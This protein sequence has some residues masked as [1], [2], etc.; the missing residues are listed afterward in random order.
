MTQGDGTNV[1]ATWTFC[2]TKLGLNPVKSFCIHI[3]FCVMVVICHVY[4]KRI[5][6]ISY[7]LLQL[8]ASTMFCQVFR[9]WLEKVGEIWGFIRSFGTRFKNGHYFLPSLSLSLSSLPPPPSQIADLRVWFGPH[10][11]FDKNRTEVIN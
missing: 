8:R 5:S 3:F 2:C 7:L 9:K 10:I 11:W 4:S 1:L 6:P